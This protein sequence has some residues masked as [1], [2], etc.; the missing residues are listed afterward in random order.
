MV[1]A[2]YTSQLCS[3]SLCRIIGNL[4]PSSSNILPE[5]L[6]M[7]ISGACIQCHPICRIDHNACC[8][9]H[10]GCL[11][12][13]A[14]PHHASAFNPSVRRAHVVRRPIDKISSERRISSIS[15]SCQSCSQAICKARNRYLGQHDKIRSERRSAIDLHIRLQQICII[16][17]QIKP[18]RQAG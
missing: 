11:Y 6:L 15:S 8:N 16:T 9:C 12:N 7:P 5:K 13:T 4:G 3:D 17:R 14:R 18:R 10:D 1:P 2:E